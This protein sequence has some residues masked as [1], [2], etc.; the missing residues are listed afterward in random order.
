MADL[1]YARLGSGRPL[2]L[3]HGLGCSRRQWN[4]VVP[5]LAADFD[6]LAVD[7]PGSGDSPPLAAGVEATPAVLADVVADLL[8]ALGVGPA[9]LVGNSL[10]G[11]VALELAGRRATASVT[12]ISPA[13][14]WAARTPLYCT[15][16]LRATRWLT[17]HAPRLLSR[18]V[19]TRIGRLAALG[20]TFGSPTRVTAAEA[21]AAIHDMGTGAGFG[22]ALQGTADIHYEATRPITAPVTVAFGSRDHLLLPHQSRV[23]TELPPGTVVG[24]LPGV[25]H[26]P[27][28]VDAPA[29]LA[30][31]AASTGRAARPVPAKAG[32]SSGGDAGLTEPVIGSG[33]SAMRLLPG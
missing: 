6:V 30:L 8:D 31:V 28:A 5:A 11:W 18:L 12:L 20:Q 19:G 13:G 16:S 2:V 1:A 4:A 32:T 9:H 29:V 3:L 25:G 15:V 17:S 27:A 14:L 26:V 22:A 24:R 33:V 21:R 23:L 7:L 10:G